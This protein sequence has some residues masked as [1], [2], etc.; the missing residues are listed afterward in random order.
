MNNHTI[1]APRVAGTS[2]N[3]F[4]VTL[5]DAEKH[6]L[7]GALEV[8]LASGFDRKSIG[9]VDAVHRSAIP[10]KALSERIFYSA[11]PYAVIRNL[12]VETLATDWKVGPAPLTSAVLV[13]LTR[14]LG[15]HHFGYPE[16]KKG[17]ILQDVHPIAGWENTLS[18]AGRV[19]FNLH[20]ESPFLPRAA[21]PEAAALMAINNDARTAT[22]VAVVADINARLPQKT[23]EVLRQPLFSYGQDD[24]FEINGYALETPRSPFLKTIDGYEESRCAIFT[25]THTPEAGK[26]LTEWLSAAEAEA[27]DVVLEPGDMLVFNNYRCI[28]GRGAVEGKRW[29]QRVYGSR[30]VHLADH[31]DLVSVWRAVGEIGIDHSF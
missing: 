11:S 14:A 21:R 5:T 28:H 4:V 9:Y 26:A 3:A 7:R 22:R 27:V 30:D 10:I 20:V 24:S 1:E 25:N 31:R 17:A 2:T 13:G 12:P 29:L 15:L 23:L 19:H 8:L 16:E 6:Q 18:N